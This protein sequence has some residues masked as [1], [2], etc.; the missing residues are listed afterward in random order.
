MIFDPRQG[1]PHRWLAV[2]PIFALVFAICATAVVAGQSPQATA[3]IST[4]LKHLFDRPEAP[5]EV[6]IVAAS[7]SHAVASWVQGEKGGRALLR[8]DGSKWS[9]LLCGGDG[10]RSAAGLTEAGVPSSDAE[11]IANALAASEAALSPGRRA[12]F[13]SF[14]A[15][16]EVAPG[17]QHHEHA[18]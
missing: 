13:A 2:A 18:H 7:G 5:V 14:G 17:D 11:T 10:L 4:T 6:D 3:E 8:R 9:I 12:L 15:T 1:S 16:I